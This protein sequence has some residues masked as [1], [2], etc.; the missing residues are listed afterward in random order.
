[1][2]GLGV[3]KSRPASLGDNNHWGSN[4]LISSGGIAPIF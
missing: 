3:D 4:V 1:L 2:A